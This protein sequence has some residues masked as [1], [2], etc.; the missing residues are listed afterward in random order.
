MGDHGFALWVVGLPGCGKSTLV[1]GIISYLRAVSN[2]VVHLEM[3]Q[4]R[5]KYHP[6]PTYTSEER[7]EA[8][9]LFAQE[10]ADLVAKGIFVVMDGAAYK[11]EMRSYAR[12][13]ISMFA[14]VQLTCSL[15]VAIQRESSRPKGQIMADMYRK[16]LKRKETGI[17]IE[18]LGDVIGVD[19]AFE[20]NTDAEL[21]ID[22]TALSPKETLGKVLHFLDSWLGNA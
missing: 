19:V 9:K 4:Q 1:R 8:Y 10:A 22:N 21:T 17:E 3:D 12:S 6:N 20:Y 5:R 7:E 14:E 11:K 2:D 13:L 16:A 15:D 18:G